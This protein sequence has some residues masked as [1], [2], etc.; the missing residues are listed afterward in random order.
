MCSPVLQ[1]S[2]RMCGKV[3]TRKEENWDIYACAQMYVRMYVC[4]HVRTHR[5][6][7]I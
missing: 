4:V 5:D 6:K 3:A 7:P 2:M 1:Y